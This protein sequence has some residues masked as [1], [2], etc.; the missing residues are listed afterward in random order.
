MKNEKI[1]AQGR[2]G[3]DRVTALFREADFLDVQA[4]EAFADAQSELEIENAK[5]ARQK[6]DEKLKDAKVALRKL[7]ALLNDGLHSQACNDPK[8]RS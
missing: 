5:A 8:Q 4:C 2:M 1:T 7:T 6:A 3:I